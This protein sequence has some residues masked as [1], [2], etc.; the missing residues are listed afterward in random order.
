MCCLQVGG[1]C[2]SD[3]L[4]ALSVAGFYLTAARGL[5][6][7]QD[8]RQ[9]ASCIQDAK[10]RC[11]ALGR[12]W[13]RPGSLHSPPVL[14]EGEKG[15]TRDRRNK[16]H[17]AA[18]LCGHHGFQTTGLGADFQALILAPHPVNGQISN[19]PVLSQN[20]NFTVSQAATVTYG[21]IPLVSPASTPIPQ[22][23]CP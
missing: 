5:T 23:P 15:G 13:Q 7:F 2:R 4:W 6:S 3:Q 22:F 17:C 12:R 8:S 9:P 21:R 18:R 11:P 1:P 16:P 19:T 20:P 14:R 10:E